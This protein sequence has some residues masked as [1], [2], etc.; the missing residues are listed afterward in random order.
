MSLERRRHIKVAWLRQRVSRHLL[1][2]SLW[3]VKREREIGFLR[4]AHLANRP[5]YRRLLSDESRKVLRYWFTLV[6][7]FFS[8]IGFILLQKFF[9]F[10]AT[11]GEVRQ[12]IFFPIV[13]FFLTDVHWWFANRPTGSFDSS[14]NLLMA[15]CIVWRNSILKRLQMM[16][17]QSIS[18]SRHHLPLA[19]FISIISVQSAGCEIFFVGSF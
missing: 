9:S 2:S 3:W 16:A 11:T 6:F 15:C 14:V 18:T 17:C 1:G 5:T 4:R 7:F 12:T 8:R 13:V 10:P 19:D